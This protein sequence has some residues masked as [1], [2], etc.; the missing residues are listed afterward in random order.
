MFSR[1]VYDSFQNIFTVIAF[2][3]IAGGFLFFVVKA[4]FMKKKKADRL[5]S[6]P[7][8]EE[9]KTRPKNKESDEERS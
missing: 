6:M 2:V 1:L 4:L 8:D 5:A 3:L 9:E 7:L